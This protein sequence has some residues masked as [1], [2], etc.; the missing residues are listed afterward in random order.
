MQQQVRHE[1]NHQKIKETVARITG[2]LH[3]VSSSAF[4]NLMEP[5]RPAQTKGKKMNLKNIYKKRVLLPE[6]VLNLMLKC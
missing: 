6:I 2:Y 3:Q 5:M 4:F 1:N